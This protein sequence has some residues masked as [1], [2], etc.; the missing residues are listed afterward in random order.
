MLQRHPDTRV[1]LLAVLVVQHR[2]PVRERT[3]RR[4]LTRETHPESLIDERCVG[5]HLAHPPVE[6]RLALAHRAAVG[7]HLFHAGMKL[8]FSG[9][10]GDLLRQCLELFHRD[11]RFG[12]VGPVLA[13]EAAPIDGERRLVVRQDGRV[14]GVALFDRTAVGCDHRFGLVG[15]HHARV[16]ETLGIKRPA[17]RMLVDLLVHQRLGNHRFV[18][19]V[20]ALPP[21][22]DQV[23]EHILVKLLAELG[24]HFDREQ[25]SFGIVAVDVEN[26]RLDHLG[27]VG[28]IKRSARVAWIGGREPDLV[29]DDDMNRS[30]GAESARLRQIESLLHDTLPGDRR[31]AVDEHRHHLVPGWVVAPVLPRAHRA[32]NDWVDDFEVRRVEGQREMHRTAGRDDVGRKPLVVLDVSS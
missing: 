12:S 32:F 18:G 23:D 9:Y 10:G 21:E 28:A 17:S 22:A 20:V 26:G 4:V 19:F 15:C 8:E 6:R 11:S 16:D 31:I 30:A 2:V 3:A 5:E 13:Q 29:I 14:G 1:P 27:Y 25:T 24:R 7:H